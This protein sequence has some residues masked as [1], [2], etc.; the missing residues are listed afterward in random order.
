L[1]NL[2]EPVA[3]FNQPSMRN[4]NSQRRESVLNTVFPTILDI[5]T[6]VL[7]A[8]LGA[9]GARIAWLWFAGR[10]SQP[11]NWSAAECRWARFAAAGLAIAALASGVT[12]GYVATQVPWVADLPTLLAAPPAVVK[13]PPISTASYLFT[14][15]LA[16]GF[17]A[18]ML[19]DPW[20]AT[21][22]RFRGRRDLVLRALP[23]IGL[24]LAV[25]SISRSIDALSAATP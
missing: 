7:S 2:P 22:M 3:R 5:Q 24:V 21:M 9:L 18:A 8:A 1:T 19:T 12:A 6:L 4:I 13:Q 20:G 14:M 10:L 25:W 23:L 16:L 15:P 11:T 17:F